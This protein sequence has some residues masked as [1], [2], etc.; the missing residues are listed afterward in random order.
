MVAVFSGQWFLSIKNDYYINANEI[1]GELSCENMI[2]SHVKIACYRV[3]TKISSCRVNAT[4]GW[5]IKQL[6]ISFGSI[7]LLFS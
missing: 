3:V 1:P 4:S 6:G 7:F 2:S 5:G